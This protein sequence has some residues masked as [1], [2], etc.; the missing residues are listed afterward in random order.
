MT[1]SERTGA[2]W[3]RYCIA[4][5]GLAWAL[6]QLYTAIAGSFPPLIQRGV[7]GGLALVL[8]L[9][10]TLDTRDSKIGWRRAN[11]LFTLAMAAFVAISAIWLVASSAELLHPRY[12]PASLDIGIAIAFSLAVI[13]A[14]RRAVGLTIPILI[15]LALSYALLGPYLP[16]VWGH[17]GVPIPRIAELLFLGTRGIW[18]SVTHVSATLISIF[19]LF[20]AVLLKT[21]GGTAMMKWA[22]ALGGRYHGGAAKVSVIMSALFG[23][24][25]GSPAANAATT[26]SI[27][28]PMM[29]QGGYSRRFAGAVESSASLAGQITPPVM[30]AAAFIMAEFLSVS[31][32][33]IIGYA[34]VPALIFI[35]GMFM[36]VHFQSKRA[37]YMPVAAQDIP[38]FKDLLT[39]DN[40]AP[41]FVPIA[42]LVVVLLLGYSAQRAG[43][44][45]IVAAIV[46]HLLGARSLKG[47]RERFRDAAAG[48]TAG[49]VSLATIAVLILGAQ[50]F[51][52]LI[53]YTGLT[54]KLSQMMVTVG[55]STQLGALLLGMLVSIIMGMGIPTVAAY[56]VV[57]AVVVPGLTR[58]DIDPAAAHLFVFYFA[59]AASITPP[60]CATVYVTSGIA[61]TPWF[62][63]AVEAV[64]LGI[65]AFLVPFVIVLSPSILGTSG[66]SP[67]ILPFLTGIA[68]IVLVAAGI[69]GFGLRRLAP[70][71]RMLAFV[72]G[73]LL[74]YPD[75]ML[76]VAGAGMAVASHLLSLRNTR[77][78][79]L[80]SEEPL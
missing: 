55:G 32:T 76:A 34:S 12:A 48:L 25:N 60:V 28:I 67:M 2:S 50:I 38:R 47:A 10:M 3:Q 21:G 36:T 66:I 44:I 22:L 59:V 7:H 79:T 62:P 53:S 15:V 6:F 49:A 16:G 70:I 17:R 71:A 41:M 77:G 19:I 68:G 35:V 65:A 52:T 43:L 56:L 5:V 23:M 64:K 78:T 57:A 61:K 72:A 1:S 11:Q 33:T 20:G 74:L 14:S 58:L 18:G 73:L 27:T 26:G 45:A 30:G 39:W 80:V 75:P 31:Y 13:E 4:G 29:I 42:A 54:V 24:I 40:T 46:V 69:A 37:G 8:L 51:L 9:I 63:V